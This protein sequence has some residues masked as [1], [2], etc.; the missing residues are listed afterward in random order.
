MSEIQ[1]GIHFRGNKVL[2]TL[3]K[4]TEGSLVDTWGEGYFLCLKVSEVSSSAT[5]LLA[6][7]DPSEVS[8]LVE[9]IND[10]D[11]C[12]VAKITNKSTQ[13][14]KFIQSN[15]SDSLTQTF[16]LSGLTLEDDE[17]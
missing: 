1:D 17:S 4:L 10:P 6:G 3:K 8:G 14:F 9:L 15:S 5:S 11:L 13:V 7:L 12:I 16:D 2:G